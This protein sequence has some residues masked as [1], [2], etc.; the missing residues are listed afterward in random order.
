[1]KTEQQ[2]DAWESYIWT[3][4][5]GA[6]AGGQHC[7]RHW[8]L[9]D[10]EKKISALVELVDD[11]RRQDRKAGSGVHWWELENHRGV[12]VT[13]NGSEKS[14]RAGKGSKSKLVK[15]IQTLQPPKP[16]SQTLFHGAPIQ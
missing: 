16:P 12:C 11:Q 7:P 8:E 6:L 2:W 4:P 1:M 14:I 10:Q 9:S 13:L 15:Q 5:R 3:D